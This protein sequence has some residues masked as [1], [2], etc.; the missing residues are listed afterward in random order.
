M[1]QLFDEL[2]GQTSQI[3]YENYIIFYDYIVYYTNELDE[4]IVD[5]I[6]KNRK[7]DKSAI[8]KHIWAAIRIHQFL[9]VCPKGAY[10]KLAAKISHWRKI[11]FKHWNLVLKELGL[12]ELRSKGWKEMFF[13]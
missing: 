10:L 3:L 2:S 1:L 13:R 11:D 7:K 12:N 6:E 4:N 9:S 5:V 8:T